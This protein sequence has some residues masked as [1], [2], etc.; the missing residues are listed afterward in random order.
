MT[1]P[2]SLRVFVYGTLKPGK[3]YYQKYCEGRAIETQAA[4][5]LGKLFALPFGYPA[6]TE[7]EDA[8]HG[9][10]LSFTDRS[11]MTELDELEGYQAGRSIDQNDYERKW[12]EVFNPSFES[13]GWVWAYVMH[14]DRIES[15]AGIYL[16]TGEW[17]A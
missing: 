12:I 1:P 9:F 4:I 13:M 3:I 16:A 14:F 5:A 8:V 11:I 15:Q 6:M 7:G 17:Q 2:Q 10:V